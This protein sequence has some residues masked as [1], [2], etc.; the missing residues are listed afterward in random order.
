M[1][2]TSDRRPLS[3]NWGSRSSKTF[4]GALTPVDIRPTNLSLAPNPA[5]LSWRGEEE[6]GI[7]FA[8]DTLLSG[9]F[10]PQWNLLTLAQEAALMEVT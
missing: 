9:Q 1:E 7:L 10:A 8:Q 3:A 5:Y 6:K 4:N 2:F